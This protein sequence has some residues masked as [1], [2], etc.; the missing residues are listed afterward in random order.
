MR[1]R[2]FHIG[3]FAQGRLQKIEDASQYVVFLFQVGAFLQDGPLSDH[4]VELCDKL[5]WLKHDFK[6]VGELSLQHELVHEAK[7][8]LHNHRI[9]S[10]HQCLLQVQVPEEFHKEDRWELLG[11]YFRDLRG[12]SSGRLFVL[13]S[14]FL[15]GR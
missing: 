6:V 11:N 3:A 1:N 8:F 12:S 10:D 15:D 9:R 14:S 7:K 2:N 13:C 4:G 5:L